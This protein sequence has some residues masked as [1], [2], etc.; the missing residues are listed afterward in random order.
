ARDAAT[1]AA[2][3]AQSAQRSVD[4]G[5]ELFGAAFAS[6]AVVMLVAAGLAFAHDTLLAAIVATLGIVLFLFAWS[7]WSRRRRSL[8]AVTEMQRASDAAIA[9]ER[10]AALRVARITQPLG[11]ASIEELAKRR[12]RA[13]ELGACRERANRLMARARATQRETE[14]ASAAFDALAMRLIV[15]TGA[16]E[17]D[18]AA[19]RARE[20][21]KSARDGLEVRLSMIDVRRTDVLAADDEFTLEAELAELVAAGVEA[22]PPEGLSP[23]AF[24]AERADME[25]RASEAR[26]NAAAAGA[27][28]RTA[29][30]HIG[31]LAA[32][33]ERA[34]ELRVQ[35]DRLERFE[36]AV[37]LARQ[38][39]D[40]R[41]REAHQKFARRLADYASGTFARVT[42]DRYLDL[43]IDPTTLAVRVR[44]PETGAIVDVERLSAGT[45]EQAYLVVRLAMVRM[46]SEGLETAPL[47]LDDPFAFWDGA[48]IERSFPILEAAANGGQIVLFTTSEELVGAA[49]DRGARILDLSAALDDARP[50]ALDRNQDLPL[51][52]Q[53]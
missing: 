8:R 1:V 15:Q 4:G 31:D 36:S 24:E 50:R 35:A 3:R 23:R 30:H 10:D 5:G 38:T 9:S 6:G 7:R 49:A 42:A 33:D 34:A 48:R 44:V 40:E 22:A 39:I 14:T 16:R 25:R 43:R 45:R 52:T 37:G 41:T 28:L 19:A 17:R 51:L 32:L 47:L 13:R 27:E 46:F 21:R 12:E 29:E 18:L 11:V 20:A 26:A 53:A 2:A